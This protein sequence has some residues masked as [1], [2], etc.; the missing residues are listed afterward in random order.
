FL[1]TG[2]PA[3]FRG[4]PEMNSLVTVGVLAAYGYSAVATFA[5]DLLPQNARYVYYEAA[6]VIVT[7]ILFGRLLEARASGRA[8]DAISMLASL[9]AK[10]ARVERDGRTLD[11]PTEDVV[12]GDIVVIRPGE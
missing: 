2:L 11:I 12:V 5:P 4:A 6:T 9:Q 8:S 3:L 1:K 10:T 7:L